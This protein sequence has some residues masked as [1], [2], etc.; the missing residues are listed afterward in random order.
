[1]STKFII[2]G[3]VMVGLDSLFIVLLSLQAQG[4]IY[5]RYC[6]NDIT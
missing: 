2:L 4:R 3:Q 6:G 5:Q 1:M